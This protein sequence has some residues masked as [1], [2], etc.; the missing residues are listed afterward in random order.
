MGLEKR[1]RERELE[2]EFK[3][4]NTVQQ[5][6]EPLSLLE[7]PIGLG[8][9]LIPIF[10]HCIHVWMVQFFQGSGSGKIHFPAAAFTYGGF[11]L[12]L[13]GRRIQISEI[14]NP[15]TEITVRSISPV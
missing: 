1:V 13:W 8:R 7:G 4:E 6:T 2:R 5:R 9:S 11:M 12:V 14:Q 10:C 3:R 15:D